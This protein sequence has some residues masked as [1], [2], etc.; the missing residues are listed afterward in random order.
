MPLTNHQR[1]IA[2]TISKNRTPESHLAGGAA[3]RVLP[4][5]FRYSEDL[6]YFH[7]SISKTTS[8]YAADAQSLRDAGYAVSPQ[9]EKP[10][11]VRALVSLRDEHTKVEWVHDSS[12]RFL[13]PL[14]T[15]DCGYLL[16]PIDVSIN[17]VL[18]CA[19]RNE[20]RDLVDTLYIHREILPLG[21]VCWAAVGKDPGF[22]PLSL[23]E[24]LKRRGRFQQEEIDKLTLVKSLNI[25]ELKAQW[26]QA[27]EEAEKFISAR[28]LSEAGSLYYS[29][30]KKRFIAPDI[31]QANVEVFHGKPGGSLP[32]TFRGDIL[33]E[34]LAE[35]C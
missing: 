13:P 9:L 33:A 7:D 1:V 12:W 29:P 10:G 6:A 26:L 31:K 18:A 34:L 4:S 21:A 23:L 30:T 35:S 20:P 5:G 27:L 16:H 17:K 19:G 14:Q 11:F 2:K 3:L 25:K 8:S 22:T 32:K 28:P 24:L 15:Q